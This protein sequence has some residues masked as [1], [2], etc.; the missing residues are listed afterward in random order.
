LMPDSTNWTSFAGTFGY[1][2]PGTYLI[3]FLT[4]IY[5][6]IAKFLFI[7]NNVLEA[8]QNIMTY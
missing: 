2:A 3:W 7:C 8:L 6:S 1:T 4:Y 5:E